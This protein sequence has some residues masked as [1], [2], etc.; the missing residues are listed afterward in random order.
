MGLN[1]SIKVLQVNLNRN[2]LATES[3]LDLAVGLGVDI[4]A[5]QEP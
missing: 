3:A 5:V 1:T 2:A 4:I